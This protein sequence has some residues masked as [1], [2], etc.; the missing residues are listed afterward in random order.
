MRFVSA[1][2]L[3]ASIAP[4]SR[5]TELDIAGMSENSTSYDAIRCAA[6]RSFVSAANLACA[7]S[8]T[9]VHLPLYQSFVTAWRL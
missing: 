9:F 1:G 5:V 7:S 4:I 2:A 6:T 8:R 3:D